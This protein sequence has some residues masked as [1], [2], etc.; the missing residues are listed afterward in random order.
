MPRKTNGTSSPRRKKT[1]AA[2]DIPNAT[3]TPVPVEPEV[4]ANAIPVAS[5]AKANG[6]LDE[7]IRQRA[8]ELYIE[9][10]G[11]A[12]DPVQ[13]WFVAEREV[14]ARHNELNQKAFAA[15]GSQV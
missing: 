11:G 9:R 7:E 5:T 13:D 4:R 6:D 10:R 8:Y 12:G 14:R 2:I 1:P 15:G 3:T